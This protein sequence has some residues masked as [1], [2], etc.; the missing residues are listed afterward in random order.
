MAMTRTQFVTEICDVVGK[1]RTASSVSATSLEDRVVNYLNWSQKR[2]ARFYN[3]NELNVLKENSATVVDTKRYPLSVGTNNLGLTR[4]KDIQ[5]I[6]LIDSENSRTFTRWSTRRFDKKFPRPANYTTGRPRIYIR[7]G[8]F[9]ELFRIPNAVYTLAIRYP[10]WPQELAAANQVSDYT[11]KDQ[12]LITGGILETYLALEEYADAKV[13]YERFLGQLKDAV[14]AEGD[15]DW[16]PEAEAHM[17]G[18]AYASGTVYDDPYGSTD[19]PLFGY[20]E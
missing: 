8:N 15:V 16:E 6:R 19:D 11:D 14:R 9:L 7:Y 18:P 5:S 17:I 20:P 12:L 13:Y 4:P 3:F 2:I 10:Q 1:S